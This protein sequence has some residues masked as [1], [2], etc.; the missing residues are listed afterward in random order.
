MRLTNCLGDVAQ[1]WAEHACIADARNARHRH[2]GCVCAVV[3]EVQVAQQQAAVGVRIG[4]HAPLPAG[5]QCGQLGLQASLLVE[6]FLWAVAIE[7][8]LQK[9]QMPGVIGRVQRH[10]VGTEV[11][12]HRLTVN[13]LGPGP[14]LRG[15]EH[16]HRPAR[17]L[18]LFLLAMPACLALDTPVARSSSS[19]P[20]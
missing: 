13:L 15:I 12:F 11:A 18:K 8:V 9:L 5:R 17:A 6:E 16:D 19:P 10:L 3:G 14:A 4:A 20:S 2:L 1:E 7:P